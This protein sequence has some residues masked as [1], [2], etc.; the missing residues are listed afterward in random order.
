MEVPSSDSRMSVSGKRRQLRL[1]ST[2][3]T[4][5]PTTA[6]YGEPLLLISAETYQKRPAF[7]QLVGERQT[8]KSKRKA[9]LC[10]KA[11]L[12][13]ATIC[14]TATFEVGFLSLSQ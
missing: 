12:F 1:K 3:G 6:N 13:V 8:A 9:I 10:I 4:S 7:V 14:A 2:P 5:V 11:S